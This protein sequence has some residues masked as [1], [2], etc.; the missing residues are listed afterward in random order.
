MKRKV[1][2]V[3]DI[4]LLL[5]NLADS[6]AIYKCTKKDK[7]L[8]FTDKSCPA[9]TN[10][11]LIYTETE[12]E[13]KRR[14]LEQKMATIKRLISN[15]QAE[16]AKEF[17]LK[18]NL[19]GFYDKQL[20]LYLKQQAEEEQQNIERDKQQQ[21]AIQ[22]QTLALQKQ[23]LEL[24]KQQVAIEKSQAE[25]Q[26]QLINNPPYYVYPRLTQPHRNNCQSPGGLAKDCP[27]MPATRVNSVPFSAGGMNPPPSFNQPMNPPQTFPPKMNPPS[28]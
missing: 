14:A 8:M 26:K 25:Q 18:N 19:T 1:L 7:T 9:D 6:A 15:K 3:A 23:Q 11:Q 22:Q 5:S 4:A 13:I 16:A 10:A 24:Q 17:A 27:Q 2:A 20:A 12:P 28:R 21:L